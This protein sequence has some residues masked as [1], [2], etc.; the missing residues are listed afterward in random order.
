MA[1]FAT[2]SIISTGKSRKDVA[3]VDFTDETCYCHANKEDLSF[4]DV[5]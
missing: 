1:L 4:G 2:P 5:N 3:E